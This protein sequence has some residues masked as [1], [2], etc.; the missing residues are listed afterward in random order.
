MRVAG[1]FVVAFFGGFLFAGPPKPESACIRSKGPMSHEA[2]PTT[3]NVELD[4]FIKTE[5]A[6]LRRTFKVKPLLRLMRLKGQ[7]DVYAA[8]S[9]NKT[10]RPGYVVFGLEL[11][12]EQL[13]DYRQ[14]EAAVAAM[15]A[16]AHAHILQFRMECELRGE[17]RE[18]HADF[19]TGY[20]LGRRKYLTD[21]KQARR[22]AKDFFE[23]GHAEFRDVARHGA[24]A[25]RIDALIAGF[26]SREL[27]ADE[28]AQKA[29]G[30]YEE[31]PPP[32]P[33]KEPE[34]EPEAGPEPEAEPVARPEPGEGVGPGTGIGPAGPSPGVL[35]KKIQVK[36]TH[37]RP[38]VHRV[39]CKHRTECVHRGP[40]IHRTACVHSVPCT[41]FV[42]CRHRVKCRH[43]IDCVHKVPCTHRKHSYDLAHEYD[44]VDGRKY[45]CTHSIPCVHPAHE[46]HFAHFFDYAHECDYQHEFDQAHASDYAHDFDYEHEFDQQHEFDLEH[47]FDFEHTHDLEHEVDEKWVP[48]VK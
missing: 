1:L 48:K 5:Q 27:A 32:A 20:Y 4:K 33:V 37:E 13:W 29:T 18:L 8:R 19:M 43:K 14:K 6:I 42:P 45:K 31:P 38:C 26:E 7:P 41:H 9:R 22:F 30:L 17:A 11:L 15:M 21:A 40:C 28:A 39:A 44:L 16:H 23:F 2:Y 34:P 36:C 25:D 10:G 35:W 46:Y 12:R 24:N 3:G 47:D